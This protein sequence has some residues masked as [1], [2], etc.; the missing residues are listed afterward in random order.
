MPTDEAIIQLVQASRGREAFEQLVPAYR[1]RVFGL[2][3]VGGAGFAGFSVWQ[4]R[5]ATP[6]APTPQWPPFEPTPSGA[7]SAGSSN[8]A[9][10]TSAA[11][12]GVA[13]KPAAG[14]SSATWAAPI[15]GQCPP[16]YPIKANDNSGIFHVPGGRSYERTVAERCYATAEAAVADGYRAAKA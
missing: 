12:A 2:A 10:S 5:S 11:F 13:T 15:D 3:L 7:S 9:A 14:T 16:G 6:P 1:R 8:S 4:R